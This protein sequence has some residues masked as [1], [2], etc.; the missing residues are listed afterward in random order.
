MSAEGPDESYGTRAADAPATRHEL[1]RAL[2]F[3]NLAVTNVRED[4]LRLAA[5]VVALTN[6]VTQRVDGLEPAP[7]APGTPAPPPLG[8][9]DAEVDLQTPG[10]IDKL[11]AADETSVGRVLLGAPEN[12]YNAAAEAPP[13]LE[14]MPIC[15]ARCCT[16]R[17]PLSTQDLDEGIIRW[18]YGAPYLIRQRESDRYCVHNDP[19]SHHCTVHKVRPTVCR[20]YH[21]KT[22]ARIWTDYDQRILAP[23]PAPPPPGDP[24]N[25]RPA[26]FDLMA[27]MKR[28]QLALTFESSSVHR[29][30]SDLVP[31]RGPA[32]P[33]DER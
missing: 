29:H 5:Q 20:T 31:H 23:D 12:K 21:C 17:F 25:F 30:Y 14:L 27:R 15:K 3:V 26:E 16:L 19:A 10:L 6:V 2:R 18:D 22:D 9:I 1:D 4:L 24:K 32:P 8:T 28:R 7:A 13:C 11:L 33:D